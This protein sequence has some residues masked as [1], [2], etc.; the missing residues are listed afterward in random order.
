MSASFAT[1]MYFFIAFPLAALIILNLLPRRFSEKISFPAGLF[2][3][4]VQVLTSIIAVLL[5]LEFN[6]KSINFSLFWDMHITDDAAYFSVDFVSAVILFCIGMVGAVSFA[7]ANC[8]IKNKIFTFTNIMMVVLLGLNGIVL[9]TD[10]FSVYVFLE[11]ASVAAYLMITVYRDTDS[12]EGAFKYFVLNA[13]SSSFILLGCA[14]LFMECSSLRFAVLSSYLAAGVYNTPA[15]VWIGF[16]FLIAGFCIKGGCAPFHGWVSSALDSA[17]SAVALVIRCIVMQTSGAYTLMRLLDGFLLNKF[18]V[19]NLSL[20][21]I[22]LISIVVGTL[23]AGAQHDL[24]RSLFYLSVSEIG[25][26]LLGA[27]CGS[28]LGYVGALLHFLNY[29]AFGS[30]MYINAASIRKQLNSTAYADM[31]GLQ[32]KMPITRITNIIA[33]LSAV[34]VPPFAGFWSKLL[35]IIALWQSNSIVI[36]VVALVASIFSAFCFLRMQ[37]IFFSKAELHTEITEPK[38]GMAVSVISLSVLTVAVG[39][40]F[41]ILLLA[42]QALGVL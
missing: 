3:C 38:N 42:I 6:K 34:G 18:T 24:K 17:P 26:I 32:K 12:M 41:P 37:Q 15:L 13:V 29:A 20:M 8:T 19:V 2:I 9:V 25:Y 14:M 5:L 7:T 28:Q 39:L 35:I 40:L 21:L 4:L 23:S 27:S 10:L 36:A 1:S 16:I 22:A 31:G 33:G 11:I 30:T